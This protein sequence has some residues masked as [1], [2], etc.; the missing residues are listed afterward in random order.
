MS[1][2]QEEKETLLSSVHVLGA[3]E[4]AL[5]PYCFPQESV[6]GPPGSLPLFLA[7]TSPHALAIM[8]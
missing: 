3:E 5:Q 6:S 7:S 8:C 1:N 2:P 4:M